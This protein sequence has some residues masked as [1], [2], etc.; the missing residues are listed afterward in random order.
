MIMSKSF[1]LCC[2]FLSLVLFLGL[3][4]FDRGNYIYEV[5]LHSSF[6]AAAFF[7]LW[8]DK[9]GFKGLL[10]KI[11][12][13]PKN[14]FHTIVYS[15]I[16]F[17]AMLMLLFFL[18]SV[19]SYFGYADNEKVFEKLEKVPAW[20]F[21][22]AIIVA[23]FTEELLFR[24]ALVARLGVIGS[25]LIFGALH[26]FYGSVMEVIGTIFVGIVLALVWKRSKS[27]LP[28]VIIHFAFNLLTILAM[29]YGRGAIL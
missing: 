24:A 1:F 3:F 27:I 26:I 2:F 29:F 13:P 14:F 15:I 25:S 7:L 16:G 8:D 4:F 10:D 11:G 23:P 9:S 18:S 6:L 12:I 28:C 19:L 22:F 20:V 21:P 17:A 5:F